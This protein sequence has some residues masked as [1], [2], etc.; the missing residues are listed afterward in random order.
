[1]NAYTPKKGL[2]RLPLILLLVTGALHAADKADSAAAAADPIADLLDLYAFV[3][4]FCE[5]SGGMGCEAPP[6]ELILALT[7]YPS[8]NGATQFSDEV[9]YHF[10]IENDQE[11]SM[12]IDCS[13]SAEQVVSCEGLDGLSVQAPV[14]EVGVNGDIRVFAGLRDDPF[15][16]D[17]GALAEFAQVGVPAFSPPGVDTRAGSNAL[18]IVLGIKTA[19]FPAGATPD[20]N[21]LKVWA[22]SER[23]AGDGLNGAFTGSW[24]NPD[25][26]GQGWVIE[27]VKSANGP[28]QFVVY[29]YGYEDG[30]QLWLIGSGPGI[31]GN[32]ATVDVMRTSGAGWGNDF[33]PDEVALDT[34]GTMSFDFSDCNTATVEFTPTGDTSLSAFSTQMVRLTSISSMDCSLLSAGQVDRVGRPGV[35]L[36]LI[37]E[38]MHDAYNTADDPADWQDL[39]GDEIEA[40]LQLLD[41]AD[42]IVGNMFYDPQTLAPVFADDRLQV[43]IQ[44]GQTG[45]YFTIESSALVPQDWNIAAG[46]TLSEDVLDG[47]LSMLI[48]AWDPLVSDYVDENDVPFLEEFPFL[49]APH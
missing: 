36:L 29:F 15:F 47:T 23:I 17:A 26:K 35:S 43:D 46:R 33:N 31:E 32:T 4:P 5:A 21:L 48:S 1:M 25:L 30:N 7:V 16:V 22:A 13:F 3:E 18:A 6:D 12:Q 9:V 49:A 10:F 2:A 40:G 24:Y 38:G 45:G 41:T 28:D 14:G 8:A 20:H 42:G 39:F 37:S 34:V 44:K 27:V 19:A 11:Q